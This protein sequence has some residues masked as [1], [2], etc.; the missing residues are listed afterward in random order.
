MAG[1][2]QP[3][4]NEQPALQSLRRGR[5]AGWRV[6][7]LVI[8]ALAVATIYVG[9]FGLPDLAAPAATGAPTASPTPTA[10]AEVTPTPSHAQPGGPTPSIGPTAE[11]TPRPTLRPSFG[12]SR[13]RDGIPA[14][15]GDELVLTVSDVQAMDRA[16]VADVLVGG[17]YVDG[18]LR[19][20]VGSPDPAWLRVRG[21]TGD[22]PLVVRLAVGP[23]TAGENVYDAAE[24]L[25]AGDPQ[26]DAAPIAVGP[27]LY[28]L[29]ARYYDK[30]P[31]GADPVRL[32]LADVEL[33]C[34]VAWPR[35]S[36]VAATGP[37]LL[38]FVF[39]SPTD[40]LLNELAVTQ[41]QYPD[42]YFFR[43]SEDCPY[44]SARFTGRTRWL[45]DGNV[46]MLIRSGDRN[47][48]L[49]RQALADARAESD[50]LEPLW[51][52][53]TTWQALRAVWA[54]YPSADIAPPAE[55]MW[56]LDGLPP[57]HW[58]IR[59]RW[60]RGV[61]MFDSTSERAE[62]QAANDPA[63]VR[64][65]LGECS[66]LGGQRPIDG[67]VRWVGAE[68]VLLLVS[69]PES[70]DAVLEAAIPRSRVPVFP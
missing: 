1:L 68:N 32:D 50:L 6:A 28:Q 7:A 9:R 25:W 45:V 24:V 62:F 18:R 65:E 14:Y 30:D 64:L 40:R 5:R 67:S 63:A 44:P 37:V 12:L 20:S 26:T 53:V 8:A 58:S 55:E 13:Y 48:S 31:L 34:P 70:V 52:P 56:C 66:G 29:V 43:A 27:L 15:I 23:F 60:L 69:G 49:A 54:V 19:D 47:T 33:D 57:D 10:V 35:H 36:Y 11:P 38:L 61:A 2:R 16:D 22:G 41:S 3:P 46:M 59:H 42:G 39:S 4:S 51:R 21:V 17:W